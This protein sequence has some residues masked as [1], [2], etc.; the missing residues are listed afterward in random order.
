MYVVSKNRTSIVNAD[1]MSVIY[2]GEDGVSI[3]AV[4]G[5][6]DKM[7]RLGEYQTR[8]YAAVALGKLATALGVSA[9][10]FM[11]DDATVELL[12]REQLAERPNKFANNGKKP[13]RRGAS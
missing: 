7:Y 11:P 5:N 13:V 3:K 4:G 12:S 9:V 8:D 2:V 10:Y 1:R 6:A